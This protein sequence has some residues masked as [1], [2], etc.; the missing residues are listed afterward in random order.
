MSVRTFRCRKQADQGSRSVLFECEIEAERRERGAH[1]FDA[2][3]AA[4]A[5]RD[6][7]PIRAGHVGMHAESGRVRERMPQRTAHR[8]RIDSGRPPAT[9][10]HADTCRFNRMTRHKPA[11]ELLQQ[12]LAPRLCAVRYART[13]RP[14]ES[15]SAR[16]TA[17]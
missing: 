5:H 15:R 7:W 16:G 1:L 14:V 12:P 13:A 3:L 10:D 8:V 9:M 11:V 6:P 2:R 4:P 17:S